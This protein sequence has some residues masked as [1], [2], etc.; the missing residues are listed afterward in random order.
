M[1]NLPINDERIARIKNLPAE[2]VKKKLMQIFDAES[3]TAIQELPAEDV[4]Q[5]FIQFFQSSSGRS[6]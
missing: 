4:K 6:L 1:D 3:A 5:N 2:S